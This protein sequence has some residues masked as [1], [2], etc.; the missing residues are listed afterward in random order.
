MG[1][2]VK[3]SMTMPQSILNDQGSV[4][5]AVIFAVSSSPTPWL[6]MYE[7]NVMVTKPQGIPC[8]Q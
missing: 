4:A 5:S 3:R 8:A 7:S 1:R 6:A 2:N